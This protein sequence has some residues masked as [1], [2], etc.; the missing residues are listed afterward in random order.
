MQR[1]TAKSSLIFIAAEGE[2]RVYG[3]VKQ[4]PGG[5]RRRLEQ[6]TARPEAVTILI[7]DRK[8]RAELTRALRL[9]PPPPH[10]PFSASLPGYRAGSVVKATSRLRTARFWVELAGATLL[11]CLLVVLLL[12]Y[13]NL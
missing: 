9:L 7:A 13:R 5:L 3:S 6:A 1:W 8:G 2:T 11:I 4:V 12:S 10:A